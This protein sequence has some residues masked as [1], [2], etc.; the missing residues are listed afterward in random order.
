MKRIR[1][2]RSTAGFSLIELMI[3]VVVVGIMFSIALP[4]YQNSM[5]KGRRSDAKSALLDSANR[6]E[7]LL[8][9]RSTYTTDMTD[10]GFAAN[11]MISGDGNYSIAAAACGGGITSCYV[12]TA[13]ARAGQAQAKDSRCQTFTLDSTGAKTAPNTDCW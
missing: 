13:T 8:L 4:A 11:P 1:T 9:D 7:R 6:Q 5:L 12:L 10:L 3:V 2:Q